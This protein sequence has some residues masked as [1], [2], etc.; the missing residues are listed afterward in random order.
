MPLVISSLVGGHTH[1]DETLKKCINKLE[2]NEAYME[3]D[4]D[5]AQ[6]LLSVIYLI[7]IIFI[8]AVNFYLHIKFELQLP[9]TLKLAILKFLCHVAMI[10]QLL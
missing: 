2:I 7:W 8:C 4:K 3:A 9:I 6:V 10:N 1:R 5:D